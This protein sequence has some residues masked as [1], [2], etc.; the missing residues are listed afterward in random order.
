[1]QDHGILLKKHG[2]RKTT[3]RLQLLS[4]F[5]EVRS[6]LTADEI[7]K[8]IGEST[9]KVTVYRALDA[10]EK[11]G[12]IHKFPGKGN[13]TRYALCHTECGVDNHVHNHAHFI[14]NVC[15]DTFCIDEVEMPE[16]EAAQGFHI[17]SSKLI[18]EGECPDCKK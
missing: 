12:L 2:L 13:L 17:Q 18:L 7:R 11:S 3:F 9:D 15:T 10:F 16:I 14:C 5:H 1:M 8:R 6:S 4:L